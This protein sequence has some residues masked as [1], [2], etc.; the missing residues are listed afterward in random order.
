MKV[1]V[2]GPA[3]AAAVA[4]VWAPSLLPALRGVQPYP[5]R[6]PE[7]L[8]SALLGAGVEVELVT[9]SPS[10]SVPL[11][12]SD[13]PLTVLIGPYRPCGRAN[14]VFRAE[15]RNL[16]ALLAQTDGA[17]VHA[18][19]TYEFAWSILADPRPRAV[20]V[21]DAPLTILRHMPNA[22]RTVRA[23]MAYRVRAG[24]FRGLAVSP[25]VARRWRREMLDRRPLEIVPNFVSVGGRKA[26]PA[27]GGGPRLVSV[28]DT[29][30]LKNLRPLLTAFRSVRR[31]H[32][33]ATL[34]LVGPG[35][36]AQDP[37]ADRAR[38]QGLAGGVEWRGRRDHGSTLDEM[39]GAHVVVHPSL[40]ESFGMSVA[41][42]M[43]MGTP[44][45]GGRSSGAVPWLLDHGRAGVLV[46]VRSPRSIADG[47]LAVLEDV[48]LADRIGSAAADRIRVDLS[49]EVVLHRH[50]RIYEQLTDR[51][52]DAAAASS[53]SRSEG[54][55]G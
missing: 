48:E 47:L 14:D 22:Y 32:P 26:A 38:A 15:R 25:Y 44:V 42:A 18:H 37:M 1:V 36:G 54:K 17:V 40:E 35:L 2:V 13:G 9:L 34:C 55:C 7:L 10:V 53:G 29:S 12:M 23:A 28:G 49:E 51:R 24:S 52:V 41:E 11:T 20:T 3:D 5:A 50:L 19:W 39:A 31:R 30:R 6:P 43:A 33:A 46:D 8:A 4:S 16:R 21:H 27:G 45:V